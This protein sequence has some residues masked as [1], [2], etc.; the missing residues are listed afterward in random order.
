MAETK[1]YLDYE[2][3]KTYH[4]K[5]K[6]EY[7]GKYALKGE[8]SDVD[9]S[10]YPT[11]EGVDKKIREAIANDINGTFAKKDEVVDLDTLKQV[12][13]ES[14]H[15]SAKIVEALPEADSAVG[16]VIYLVKKDGNKNDAY[17]EYLFIDGEFELIGDTSTDVDLGDYFTKEEVQAAIDKAMASVDIESISNDDIDLL[18]KSLPE[19]F[20]PY[21]ANGLY[22]S[23]DNF[24]RVW[25]G[26]ELIAEIDSP[27]KIN[28]VYP[29]TKKE[30]YSYNNKS[31]TRVEYPKSITRLENGSFTGHLL[32][33]AIIPE[34]ISVIES[35]AIADGE[36]TSVIIPDSVTSIGDHAFTGNKLQTVS[37]PNSVT[38]IGANAFEANQLTSVSIPD[39]ITNIEEGTFGFNQ[40]ISV[41][42]PNSVTNIGLTAFI[43]NQL[44]S[45]TIPDSVT[46]IG[47]N[48]FAANP[49]KTVY[50]SKDTKFETDSFPESAEIIYRD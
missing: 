29:P 46:S 17:D 41:S 21:P 38:N 50:M 43:D 36:L 23:P 47:S 1:K 35:F 15:I 25:A 20:V 22:P 14:K 27:T 5:A 3:L 2:G 48:A 16:N 12:V 32:T 8:T 28:K 7:D 45:V 6:S 34:N 42:I 44:T 24:L 19:G 4:E 40:L 31:V 30:D 10:N 39:S 37:I 26:E 49:L 9:L 11:N 18:F 13:A 33:S